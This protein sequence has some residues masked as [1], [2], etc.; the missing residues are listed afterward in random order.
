VPVAIIVCI[1][2]IS[3][4]RCI[5]GAELLDELS[6]RFFCMRRDGLDTLRPSSTVTIISI[7]HAFA[8]VRSQQRRSLPIQIVF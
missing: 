2:F 8:S 6:G 7:V 1:L 3:R 4:G 5:E